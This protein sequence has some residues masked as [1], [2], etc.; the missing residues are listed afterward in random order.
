MKNRYRK[1][2]FSQY[3]V[4]T[5]ILILIIAYGFSLSKVFTRVPFSDEFVTP[6]AAGRTWL[7]EGENPYDVIPHSRIENTFVNSGY[8]AELTED[9]TLEIPLVSLTFYLP[10]SLL[11]Y[12]LSRVIWTTIATICAVVICLIS[13][14]ISG[15]EIPFYEK[16]IVV[17]LFTF[18]MPGAFTIISGRLTPMIISFVMLGI[19]LSM[20]GRDKAAGFILSLT[21]GSLP[22]TIV[23]V[24]SILIWSI[25][26]RK[27]S[28][29]IAYFSGALFQTIISLLLL[30]SWPMDW[31]QLIIKIFENGDWLRTPLMFLSSRLPGIETFLLV[32]LH[33]IVL[34]YLIVLLLTIR[35]KTEI[36]FI[37]KISM[38]LLLSV[39]IT[40]E[41]RMDGMFY[42]LPG[43]FLVFRFL[44]ERWKWKGRIVSWGIIL[45]ASVGSWML[46]YPTLNFTAKVTSPVLFIGLPALVLVCRMSIL[47]WTLEISRIPDQIT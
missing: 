28:V 5:L 26:H 18:W 6:W 39:F 45:L 32:L 38:V 17:L 8:L 43:L 2:A 16:V 24:L 25:S 13:L 29:L 34:I 7:L 31:L 20:N 44:S 3:L 1:S 27:W 47:F 33:S 22:I 14:K 35:K 41:I 30:P 42:L 23:I 15:W 4:I 21:I 19:L 9:E 40:I 10:F 46:Q 37:W 11:P 36:V 12:K